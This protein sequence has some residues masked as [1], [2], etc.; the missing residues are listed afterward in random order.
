MSLDRLKLPQRLPEWRCSGPYLLLAMLLHGLVLVVPAFSRTPQ[1]VPPIPLSV[2]LSPTSAVQ[3]LPLAPP[4][5]QEQRAAPAKTRSKPARPQATARPILAMAAKP[6]TEP[7]AVEFLVPVTAVPTEAT[8][9]PAVAS[10]AAAP[11]AAPSIVPARFDAAYLHNPRPNYPALSRRLGEEGKVL[12][13]VRVS[14]DGQALA[15]KLEKS[16]NF[17]R[18]DEA[19]LQ[20]VS[21][22]RF[23]PARRGDEAIEASVVVP[24]VFRLEG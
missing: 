22:W 1:R 4:P 3:A 6:A 12:L 19:A 9:A 5:P 15:V 8:P 2:S 23:I 16:S 11:A 10:A 18:L 17:T 24:I 21:R 14:E 13:K 7:A 20:I